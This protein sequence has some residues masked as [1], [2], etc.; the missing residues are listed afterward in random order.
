MKKTFLL[1]ALLFLCAGFVSCSND[2]NGEDDPV[3]PVDPIE[4]VTA[5]DGSQTAT[6]TISH[7]NRTIDFGQFKELIDISKVQVTFKLAKG[8]VMKSPATTQATVSLINPL[9]VTVNDGTKDISYTMTGKG[10]DIPDPVIS[11]KV[12]GVAATI[13]GRDIMVAYSDGMD[14]SAVA[15]ELE[16][17]D[18]ATVTS[19]DP[20]VFDL[21]FAESAEVVV[22]YFD[23]DYTYTVKLSGYQNPFAARGWSDVTADYGQVPDY[24]KVYK[25]PAINNLQGEV[26]YVVLLLKGATMGIAGGTNTPSADGQTIAQLSADK[27]YTVYLATSSTTLVTMVRDGEVVAEHSSYSQPMLAQDADGNFSLEIGQRFDGQ[28]Y[29]FPF[30]KN[31]SNFIYIPRNVAD[32]TPW[33]F[34]TACGS[35]NA[36]IWDGVTVTKNEAGANSSYC[37]YMEDGSHYARGGFGI[38]KSGK[39]ILFNTQGTVTGVSDCKGQ[40][41]ED[42]AAELI[43]V[44]CYRAGVVEGSGTPSLVVNGKHTAINKNDPTGDCT[45]ASL[46]KLVGALAVK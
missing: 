29:S 2:D 44:G 10:Q 36:L 45:G 18:G 35:F 9:T 17:H 34:K 8:V 11:A 12:G 38:L 16:L 40:T 14:A 5:V 24:I 20:L 46:K 39:P 6:A 32:G 15:L 31:A 28:F 25:I 27:A 22:N 42:V 37:E 41:H 33:N 43:A 26:G 7:E 3:V 1:A 19:P 13:D 21:E 30:V 4:S 23:T